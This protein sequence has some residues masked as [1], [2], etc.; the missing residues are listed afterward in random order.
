ML[1]SFVLMVIPFQVLYCIWGPFPILYHDLGAA[2]MKVVVAG[3]GGTGRRPS[4]GG[5]GTRSVQGDS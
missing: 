4:R 1:G 2:K 3:G 5:A